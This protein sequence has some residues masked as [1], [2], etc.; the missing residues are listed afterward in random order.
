MAAGPDPMGKRALFWLPV[1]EQAVE[2]DGTEPAEG[3]SH[4]TRPLVADPHRRH[5]RP[6]GKHALFS[7]AT[8]AGEVEPAT[9][10]ATDPLPHRGRLTVTCS[11]CGSVTRVGAV[12]FLI[13]QFPVGVWL[14]GRSFDRWMTCPA[15]R[16]RTWTGV[17]LGR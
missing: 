6:A 9:T 4:G 5:A 3:L 16:H 17:T 12:E 10:T 8:P 2:G 11:S 1:E 15:C 7:A 14:P 13:L